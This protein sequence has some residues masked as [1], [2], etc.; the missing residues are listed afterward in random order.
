MIQYLLTDPAA[1]NTGWHYDPVRNQPVYLFWYQGQWWSRF[2]WHETLLDETDP[3]SITLQT[4]DIAVTQD[5]YERFVHLQ[6][7]SP[8][9]YGDRAGSALR[10]TSGVR[11]LVQVRQAP[12]GRGVCIQAPARTSPHERD[13]RCDEVWLA[14]DEVSLVIRALQH[15]RRDVLDSGND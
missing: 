2:V 3:R 8:T 5:V 6:Y 15:R 4:Q 14:D 11:A 13:P 9:N 1:M 10:E 7:F 12:N